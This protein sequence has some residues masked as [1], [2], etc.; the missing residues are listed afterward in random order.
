MQRSF[1]ELFQSMVRL[2]FIFSNSIILLFVHLRAPA[3]RQAGLRLC[4]KEKYPNKVDSF[5]YEIMK[6]PVFPSQFLYSFIVFSLFFLNFSLYGQDPSIVSPS[7][8]DSINKI[9]SVSCMPCH[10]DAGGV[11]S[12]PKLNF[13]KWTQYSPEKQ[14][15]RAAK[16]YSELS[17]GAMPPKAARE[18]SP[19]KI[20]TVEQIGTIKRWSES[21]K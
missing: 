9:V 6:K 7:L 13:E 17:K 18:K 14:K 12:R 21:F 19:E 10:S 8:P 1:T 16:M 3:Y 2:Q 15:E 4:G 20:P 11:F 5:I